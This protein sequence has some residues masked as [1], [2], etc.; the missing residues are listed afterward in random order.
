[1]TVLPGALLSGIWL[2]LHVQPKPPRYAGL[3]ND[4]KI[5]LDGSVK[6]K[7]MPIGYMYTK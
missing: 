4:S 5:Y 2:F 7:L 6:S 3:I 1:M